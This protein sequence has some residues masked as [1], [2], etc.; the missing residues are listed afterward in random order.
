MKKILWVLPKNTFPV[1]DGAKKANFSLLSSVAKLNPNLDILVFN[2]TFE[3]EKEYRTHFKFEKLFFIKRVPYKNKFHKLFVLFG[4]LIKHPSLP[5][6]ASFFAESNVQKQIEDILK[7]NYDAIVFDGLH[8]FIGFES[9]SLPK[10]IYRAHNVESE[11]WFT[12]ANQSSNPLFATLLKWQGSKINDLEKRLLRKAFCTWTIASEDKKIF[13]NKIPNSKYLDVNVGLDFN[14]VTKLNQNEKNVFMFLGKLDWEPNKDG[15]IW[16]LKEVWPNVNKEK[17][18]LKIAGS[19][20]ASHIM[21]FLNQEGIEFLGFINNV[22][23]LYGAA[24]CSIVPIQYGSGTRIKVIE[25]VSKNM[26]MISTEMGV[27]GSGLHSHNYFQAKNTEDWIRLINNYD[28][29][30]GIKLAESAT[31][32]LKALYDSKTIALMAL[33][34]LE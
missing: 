17:S 3:N 1:N 6:T 5:I 4:Q 16:F 9:Y 7:N 33:N 14:P 30:E 18:V 22:D 28:K 32:K 31:E 8:P 25:S 23:D 19:G 26:P 15:L 20:D 10:V 13:I 2:E 29:S 21:P 12:K 24:D 27:Q 34:S 11:L